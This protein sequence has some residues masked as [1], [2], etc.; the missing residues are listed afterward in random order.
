MDDDD[1]DANK[2]ESA[3][4]D[5]ENEKP[6]QENMNVVALLPAKNV[7]SNGK[8]VISQSQISNYS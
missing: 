4:K 8:L 3:E 5:N 2:K 7:Q 6:T 1:V